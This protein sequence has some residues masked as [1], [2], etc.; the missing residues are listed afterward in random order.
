MVYVLYLPTFYRISV[1]TMPALSAFVDRQFIH[2]PSSPTASF[3]GQTVIVTGSNT[4][5]G[6]EAARSITERGASKVIIACRN[7]EKGNAAARSIQEST[8]CPP[9][10]VEV[11]QLDNGSYASVQAFGER[12]Q[13]ELPRLDAL[14]LNAGIGTRKFRMTEDNEET[15]T[16]NVVSLALLGFMLHSKLSE[17]GKNFNTTAHLSITASELYEDAKFKES[18]VPAGQIFTTLNDEHRSIMGDRYNVSKLIEIFLVKQMA[19]MSPVG[20]SKVAINCVAPGYA[21]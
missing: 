17:T 21:Y 5:L 13:A 3:K 1:Q 4:G 11:W 6:L 9:G 20:S 8:S 19:G 15:I 7:V 16:T 12:A 2:W 14:L 18:Q 10:T